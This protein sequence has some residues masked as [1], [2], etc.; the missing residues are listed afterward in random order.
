MLSYHISSSLGKFQ[1][2]PPQHQTFQIMG[3]RRGILNSSRFKQVDDSVKTNIV[4]HTGYDFYPFQTE[5]FNPSSH[6]VELLKGYFNVCRKVHIDQLLIHGP[7][8]PEHLKYFEAGLTILKSYLDDFNKSISLSIAR[9]TAA[10]SQVSISSASQNQ[11]QNTNCEAQNQNQIVRATAANK[12]HYQ[13]QICIEMP[14]FCKSMFSPNV[15]LGFN[16]LTPKNVYSFTLSYFE[17]AIKF[18]FDIVIDTAHLYGNGLTTEEMINVLEMFKNNYKYIHLNGNCR[19][20]FKKDE[21][22]TLTDCPGFK[23]NLI[24]NTDLLL[25]EVAKLMNE[26]NKI[27]ISEQKC[28][29]V[30]YFKSLANKYG[31]KLNEY[32]SAAAIDLIIA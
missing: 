7:D 8:K 15:S 26:D 20:Q 3:A 18:G 9:A 29:N 30:K 23:P 10:N 14:V 28:N 24:P 17:T 13:L 22:T 11:N 25:T 2:I 12:S 1:S 27:C 6:Q 16:G 21:H 19:P 5:M 32:I 31:F 4:L